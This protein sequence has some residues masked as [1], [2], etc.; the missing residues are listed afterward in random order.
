MWRPCPDRPRFFLGQSDQGTTQPRL[1]GGRGPV[2]DNSRMLLLPCMK[3][4][5]MEKCVLSWMSR[6]RFSFVLRVPP[7]RPSCSPV[8]PRSG[9]PPSQILRLLLLHRSRLSIPLSTRWCRC[10]HSTAV[11]TT[12]RVRGQESRAVVVTRWSP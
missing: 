8:C 1:N 11:T 12:C 7:S 5:W 4:S 3:L 9:R 2:S 6:R 10:G